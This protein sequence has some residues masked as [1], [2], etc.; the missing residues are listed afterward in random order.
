MKIGLSLPQVGELADPS[1]VATV[2]TQAESAGFDSLWVM[3]RLMAPLRPRSSYPGT[4]DGALPDAHRRVLDPLLVLGAA[5][6]VTERIRLGTNVLVAP[7]YPPIIL[8]R[9]LTTLDHLSGGRLTVGFGLGW[10]ADEYEAAGVPMQ[11]VGARLDE[12]LDVLDAIWCDDVVEH[13]GRFGRIAAS[14]V[15]PK[16]V[17]RPRPPVLLAAFTPAGLDRIARRADG[18]LPVGLPHPVLRAMW[19][20]LRDRAAE[21][22]RDPGD[23]RLVVRANVAISDRPLDGADRPVFCGTIDQIRDDVRATQ[24]IGA[25]ELMLDLQYATRSPAELL[26]VAEALGSAIREPAGVR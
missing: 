26:E 4:P 18:W 10:S 21:H 19:S 24:E 2:A 5:A 14:T 1:G 16:P 17:Q 11:D 22:G 7:W 23:L 15:E 8:A 13:D 12:T 3:D 6:A 25:D 20:G 9:S